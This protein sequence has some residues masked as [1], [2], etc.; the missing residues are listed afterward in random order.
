MEK[1]KRGKKMWTAE[2]GVPFKIFELFFFW[3]SP[4]ARVR[5]LVRKGNGGHLVQ[6]CAAQRDKCAAVVGQG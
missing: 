4:A 1:K 5:A 2:V 3:T 6:G